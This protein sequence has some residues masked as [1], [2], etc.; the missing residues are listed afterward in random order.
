MRGFTER[1]C[2]TGEAPCVG[3]S[4]SAQFAPELTNLTFIPATDPES[5]SFDEGETVMGIS[6]EGEIRAYPL[7][8]MAYASEEKD[9]LRKGCCSLPRPS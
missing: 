8:V 3:F 1:E 6:L 2:Q 7:R 9:S 5:G 4:C